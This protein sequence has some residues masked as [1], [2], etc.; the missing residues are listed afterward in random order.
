[1]LF[2]LLIGRYPFYHQMVPT[3]FAKISRGKF[4]IPPSSGLSFDARILLRSMIRVNPQ[5]RPYPC[6]ILA[7]NWFKQPLASVTPVS[8]AFNY[9]TNLNSNANIIA[10][11]TF[12]RKPLEAALSAPSSIGG[13]SRPRL[14]NFGDRNVP[15]PSQ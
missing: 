1:M 3:M 8:M 5:E 13:M 14:V 12:Q 7:H 9:I 2:L 6:E 4:M 15:G 11:P 10:H